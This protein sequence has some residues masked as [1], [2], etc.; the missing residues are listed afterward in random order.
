M[1]PFSKLLEEG[2]INTKHVEGAVILVAN[3]GDVTAA[4][5]FTVC[6]E[7]VQMLI[8]SFKHLDVTRQRGLHFRNKFYTCVRADKHS[9][10]TKCEGHGLILVRT[11]LYV[12]V[13]TYSQ[14]M[15]PSICVEAVEKL[16]EYLREKGK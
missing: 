1:N 6:P 9:I 16:A 4:S 3:T 11:A 15:Y 2:L 14:S 5:N 7:Q 13:A 8:D 12:I 10:Y